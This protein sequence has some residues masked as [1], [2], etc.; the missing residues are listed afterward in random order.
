MKKKMMVP[1]FK[2]YKNEGRKWTWSICYDYTMA[3]IVDESKTDMILV[4]DSMGNV[5]LGMGSTIPV[6][7]DMMIHHIKAVVKGAPNTFIVGD[8]PFASYNVSCEQAIETANRIMKEG[9]CDCVKLEGGATMAPQI[10]AIVD[11]GIPVLGHI[12]LTPQT[13][14]AMGGFKVQGASKAAADKLMA[15]A[16]A[17]E[18]AGA[19]AICVECVP[20]VVAKKMKE[21]LQIPI[22]G[23]G[24]GPDC[25]CQELN[26]YD[27]CGL[28]GDFKPKFVKQ[29]LQ[30]RPLIVG[31]LDQFYD[32]TVNG[33]FPT[34]EYSYNTKVEGY[35]S[36][37]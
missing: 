6:T 14:S 19:F 9:G 36:E 34:P 29:Y 3:S 17:I 2:L 15:D 33:V 11:A 13:A 31:A 37:K 16:N 8:M 21:T 20:S 35:D 24:A 30:L 23:I 25:D 27:M 7:V 22:L 10:K 18:E 26:L 1:D 28:F 12:G 32:D 4:G 5:M